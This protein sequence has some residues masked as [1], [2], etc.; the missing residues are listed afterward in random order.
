MGGGILLTP[1]GRRRGIAIAVAIP[2][3]LVL[4]FFFVFA[5]LFTDGPGSLGDPERVASLA[6]TAGVFVVAALLV[7]WISRG[8]GWS[9]LALGLPG[10]AIAAWY[11]L[12]EPG[13]AEL[14]AAY[15]TL[16]AIA[17]VSGRML[18]LRVRRRRPDAGDGSVR[19][20]RD[21][22]HDSDAEDDQVS[23][24]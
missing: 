15:V 3:G 7:A 13:V 23:G 20:G 21:D 10:V 8:D 18:A 2:L 22:E 9:L 12:R 6:L 5:P 14:A 16:V 11:V 24:S 4:G 1:K 19:S 17:L